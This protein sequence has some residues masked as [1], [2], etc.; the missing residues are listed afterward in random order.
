MIIVLA[1]LQVGVES[2]SLT[3][4]L[5][6]ACAAMPGFFILG[7][8][9]EAYILRGQ[10]SYKHFRGDFSQEL[11]SIL[12]SLCGLALILSLVSVIFYLSEIAA[13]VFGGSV[14][15]S[16]IAYFVFEHHLAKSLGE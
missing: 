7:G 4:A 14:A 5:Y 13:F 8:V 10:K 2:T 1:L 6:G 15:L 9:Y 16:L 12:G 11:T 3:V